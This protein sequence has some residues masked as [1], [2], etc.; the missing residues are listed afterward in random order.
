M[1]FLIVDDSK[2]ARRKISSFVSELGYEVISEAE[3]GLEAL[4]LA[5]ELKPDIIIMDLEMPVMN[6][7]E[8]TK[9]I[10]NVNNNIKIV[11]ATSSINKKDKIAALQNGARKILEKPIARPASVHQIAGFLM[12]RPGDS[13]TNQGCHEYHQM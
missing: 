11:I 8:A 2:I 6:G 1:K 5:N 3:N 13:Y 10:C 4:K 12:S 7:S 9:K